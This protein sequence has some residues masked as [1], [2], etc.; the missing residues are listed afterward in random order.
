VPEHR[1][2]MIINT[3]SSVLTE[4][5]QN[6]GRAVIY[7]LPNLVIAILIVILGWALGALV[8]RIVARIIRS[9]RLDEGLRRAG[10]EDVVKRGG[11]S[12]NT[13]KFVGKLVEWFIIIVFLVAAFDVLGLTQVTIFLQQVVLNYIPQVIVAVLI[14]LVAGV[15]GDFMQKLVTT[16]SRTAEVRTAHLLGNVTKWAIWIFAILVAL[17]QLGIADDFIHTLFTGF[18]VALSLALGLSFGL[19]GQDAAARFIEKT[20]NE[21]FRRD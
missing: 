11:I 8:G 13:G 15:L 7:F 19:G 1:K 14:L 16:S 9:L 18:V 12:L 2:I 17:S 20:R 6:L 21:T 10:V 4:S 3:W 5:F